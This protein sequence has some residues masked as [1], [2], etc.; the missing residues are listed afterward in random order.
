MLHGARGP[1]TKDGSSSFKVVK[2]W[3]GVF[4]VAPET[5]DPRKWKRCEDRSW[6][7]PTGR[8][9]PSPHPFCQRNSTFFQ[10]SNRTAVVI[11]SRYINKLISKRIRRKKTI[12]S[13]RKLNSFINLFPK[14][15]S[16]RRLQATLSN[17]KR[18][19]HLSQDIF[20]A[21]IYF[22]DVNSSDVN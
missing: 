11:I 9:F 17:L 14:D 4:Q 16:R 12:K 18:C 20:T 3:N 22:T 13:E 15:S 8:T 19:T 5:S 10:T 1:R 21:H 6:H 7:T 2:T